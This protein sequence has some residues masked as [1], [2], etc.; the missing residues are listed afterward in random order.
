MEKSPVKKQRTLEQR[1]KDARRNS[2]IY[3]VLFVVVGSI[4]IATLYLYKDRLAVGDTRIKVGVITNI[5]YFEDQVTIHFADNTI[6]NWRADS[7]TIRDTERL[8]KYDNEYVV[9]TRI[10]WDEDWLWGV[11]QA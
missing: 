4:L 5:D 9:M 6:I 11:W 8:V 1:L 10:R 3:F 7:R 2:W